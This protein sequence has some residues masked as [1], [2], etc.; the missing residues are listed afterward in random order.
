MSHFKFPKV[1]I[2]FSKFSASIF[3]ES[4]MLGIKPSPS[5]DGVNAG[6]SWRMKD[7]EEGLEDDICQDLIR[8]MSFYKRKS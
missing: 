5:D 3:D 4:L 1:C 7:R 8:N 2:T 6:S